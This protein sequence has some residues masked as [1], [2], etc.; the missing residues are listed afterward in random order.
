[1]SRRSEQDLELWRAW[2]ADPNEDNLEPLLQSLQGPVNAKVNE[3]KGAPVPTSAVKAFANA[4]AIKALHTYNP[5]RGA[6]VSTF[7]NWHLKKVR[8]FVLKHQN[9]GRIPEHRAYNITRFKDAKEEMTDKF[10]HPPDS[11]SLA[12]NL[13]WSQAEVDRMERELRPDLI[14]SL[15][16]EPDRLPDIQ[17]AREKDVLRYI[18]H[19]LTPDERLVFEYTLGVY[20]KPE[21]S[22]TEI[23]RTMNISL[24][25]VSRIR[26]K[27]DRKL[28]E[29]GV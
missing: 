6:S 24:P 19:S 15:S 9:V 23:A 13:G 16:P 3:F 8:S 2:K 28:R 5:K 4:Q 10:G 17:S 26:A 11:L 18:H 20:G 21:L 12:E 25:K 14:A 1:M 7:V 22:A 29:R 27:I